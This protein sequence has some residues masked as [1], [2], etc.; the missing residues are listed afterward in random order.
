MSQIIDAVYENGLLRPLDPL[1]LS[2]HQHVRVTVEAVP[3]QVVEP[4]DAA[5]ADPLAGIRVATGIPD[6]AEHFDD[7]RFG[8]RP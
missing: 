2:E 4:S 1:E 6:L 3:P 5:L 8:R 7:Y